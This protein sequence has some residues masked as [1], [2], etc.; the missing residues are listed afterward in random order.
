MPIIAKDSDKEEIK[1]YFLAVL[2]LSQSGKEFPINLDDVW[3]LAYSTKGN[4]L[5]SLKENFMQDIDYQV[6]IQNDK[7][8]NGGRPMHVYMIST[9]CLEYFIARKVRPVFE[10]YRLVFHQVANQVPHSFAEALRLA[11]DQQEQIEKLMLENEKQKPKVLFADSII[12]SSSSCLIGELAKIITQN[13][14]P[15]GQNRLF[16]WMRDNDYLGKKGERKNIPNQQYVENGIFE[17]KKNTIKISG[18]TIVTTTTKVT[19][20]GQVYFI[21]KFLNK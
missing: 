7:N 17:I 4:A 5:K 20:K 3:M 9:S 13:G 21:N 19:G 14:Y 15:I 16:K 11:A 1:K 6:F 10:V 18:G 12:A 8:L 2:K